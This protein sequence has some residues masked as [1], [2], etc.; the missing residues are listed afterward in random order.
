MELSNALCAYLY[1]TRHTAPQAARQIKPILEIIDVPNSDLPD[2]MRE[3]C[4]NL[5]RQIAEQIKRI[6]A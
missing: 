3:Q 5:M 6:N 2:L 4:H 1:E